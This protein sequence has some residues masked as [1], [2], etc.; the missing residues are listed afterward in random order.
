M[1]RAMANAIA[2]IHVLLLPCNYLVNVLGDM[3]GFDTSSRLNVGV[4][5]DIHFST[6]D[7]NAHSI[8]IGECHVRPVTVNKVAAEQAWCLERV[9]QSPRELLLTNRH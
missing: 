9:I 4:L 1:V 6:L 3:I 2:V 7:I 5:S 8:R